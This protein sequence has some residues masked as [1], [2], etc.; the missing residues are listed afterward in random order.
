MFVFLVF[1]LATIS[2]LGS[3]SSRAECLFY[4]LERTRSCFFRILFLEIFFKIVSLNDLGEKIKKLNA[5]KLVLKAQIHAGGR[6]KAGGVKLANN[7][8][9]ALVEARKMFGKV[10]RSQDCHQS[11]HQRRATNLLQIQQL[12]YIHY[13]QYLF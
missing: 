5:K 11:N 8:N 13:P 10:F 6:G 1:S 9:E 7:K 12:C 2:I 3:L 4:F